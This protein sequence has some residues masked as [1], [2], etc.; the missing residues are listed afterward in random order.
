MTC[1]H[2]AADRADMFVAFH[3]IFCLRVLSWYVVP[4]ACGVHVLWVDVCVVGGVVSIDRKIVLHDHRHCA[5]R[6]VH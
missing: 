5:I 1:R 4:P 6:I 3:F 2:L